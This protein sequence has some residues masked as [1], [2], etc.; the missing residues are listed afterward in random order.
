MSGELI[1]HV[2]DDDHAIRRALI[3]LAEASGYAAMA[4]ASAEDFL[5]DL[6]PD[7]AGCVITDLKMPGLSGM[8]LLRTVQSRDG[9]L[10]VVLITGHG[11]V[12]LAVAALKAGAADF[13]EKPFDGDAFLAAVRDALDVRQAALARR[14]EIT[15]LRLRVSRLTE[16]ETE[17]MALIAE[18]HSNA[19]TALRLEISV[20]TVENHRA[21][22]LEKMEARGLSDLVRMVLRLASA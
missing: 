11:Q 6:D 4:H 18:G 13:I 2:I 1:V 10:P 20:R 9:D 5:R 15:G 7:Q 19:E 16:R 3:M 14:R 22:V 21:K 8:D 17:V 12:A